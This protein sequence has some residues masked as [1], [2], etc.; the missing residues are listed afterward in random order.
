MIRRTR[1]ADFALLLVLATLGPA[2]AGHDEGD[3]GP[4]TVPSHAPTVG[5]ASGYFDG[6]L[7]ARYAVRADSLYKSPLSLAITRDGRT[8][9]VVCESSDELLRVDLRR[10]RVTGSVRVGRKPFDVALSRDE[11]RAYVSNRWDNTVSVIDLRTFR[12]VDTLATGFNPHGLACDSA[13]LYVANMTVGTVSVIGLTTGREERCLFAGPQPFEVALSPDGGSLAVTS[14]LSVRLPFRATPRTEITLID[15]RGGFVADRRMAESCVIQQGATWTP[16]GR[17]LLVVTEI[18]RNLIP[19]T[20]MYRGWMV[21]YGLIVAE[22]GPRGRVAYLLLD[23][24]NRYCT[25][26]YSIVCS[27]DGRYLYVSSSGADVVTVLDWNAI[28]R[29][30]RLADGRIGI[31]PDTVALYARHLGL[32][33]EYTVA[34]IPTGRNP[35]D[36]AVSPDGR[37]VYVADR[38]SDAITVI[39]ARSSI[40]V[41]SI[42][43]GGPKQTTEL[44]YGE[45][46]FN[47][48]SISFQQQ[49]S[50]NTCHP[51]YHV[52]GILY[53]IAADGA[54]GLNIVDNRTL[55]GVAMTGPFKWSA[56]NPTLHRQE[57][58]RAAQ[59]FFR[60]HGFDPK[61]VDAIVHFIESL[62]L[63]PNP[64]V[65]PDG[66]LTPAQRRGKALFER[67][68][69]NTGAYVPMAN[70]CITCHPPPLYMSGKRHNVGSRFP[71]DTERE[72]DTPQ[73]NR[74]YESPPYLHDGRCWSLEEIWTTYNPDDLHGQTNDMTKEQLN[75]LIEY[76]KTF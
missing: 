32:S 53:D 73:L 58:P 9:F 23:D 48:A 18:P 67:S 42:D 2:M 16:D 56:K 64:H 63:P 33:T 62:P 66:R 28:E 71:H 72:F 36:L 11:R 68:R 35:K 34:R 39:D 30:L 15:T 40:V 75:D 31:S 22:R 60:S 26:P 19:E 49:T 70:R 27:P 54:M 55:R 24:V 47:F 69:T 44:R 8:L 14:Q 20:Q 13:K 1:C 17:W 38:L 45:Q 50:C 29:V 25:D 65:A 52:D 61:G 74:V 7:R 21:T 41:G 5:A 12:V 4:D 37:R 6:S 76:M 46:L 3:R 57:G 10:E 51:E 59:L 43:L